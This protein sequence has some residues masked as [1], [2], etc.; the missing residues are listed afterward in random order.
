MSGLTR[1][2]SVPWALFKVIGIMPLQDTQ[3]PVQRY[4]RKT[5][6]LKSNVLIRLQSAF[7]LVH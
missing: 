5:R 6:H 7:D 1:I 3:H 4:F 2:G